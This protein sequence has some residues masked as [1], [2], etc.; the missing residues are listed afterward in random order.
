MQNSKLFQSE[1][2]RS[3]WCAIRERVTEF[4][5]FGRE[6]TDRI[7]LDLA[8]RSVLSACFAYCCLVRFKH[9]R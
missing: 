8:R 7:L 2:E 1:A 5:P 9:S 6:S 4:R 3:A